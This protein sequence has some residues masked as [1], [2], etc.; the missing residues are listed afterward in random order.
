MNVHRFMAKSMG[1]NSVQWRHQISLQILK[2]SKVNRCIYVKMHIDIPLSGNVVM[3][4][5]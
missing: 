1:Y 4:N 3:G 5:E 2:Y